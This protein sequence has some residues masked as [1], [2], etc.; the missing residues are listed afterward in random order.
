M[1]QS[2]E[3]KSCRSKAQFDDHFQL[4][5]SGT[6]SMLR[7]MN[8]TFSA[9]YAALW[10]IVLFQAVLVLALLR[11]L[12]ELRRVVDHVD[13]PATGPLPVGDAAPQFESLDSRTGRAMSLQ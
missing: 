11:Q 12:V 4:I 9:T 1:W 6:G 13:L 10:V 5:A 3:S 8:F 2:R 7:A